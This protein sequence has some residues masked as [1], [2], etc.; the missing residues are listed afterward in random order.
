VLCEGRI[1][2]VCV[3]TGSWAKTPWPDAVRAA[4]SPVLDPAG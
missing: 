2:H 1:R 4:F 3:D